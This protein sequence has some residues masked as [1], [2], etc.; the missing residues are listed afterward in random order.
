METAIKGDD[1]RSFAMIED[2]VEN[3]RRWGRQIITDL[4][5]ANMSYEEFK[6]FC[7]QEGNANEVICISPTDQ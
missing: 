5:D 1:S 7:R 2:E 4:Q 3:E 6:E